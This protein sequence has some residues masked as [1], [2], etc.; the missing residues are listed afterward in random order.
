MI[1]AI[2]TALSDKKL[3]WPEDFNLVSSKDWVEK[4]KI[5]PIFYLH[6]AKNV[7]EMK[8]YENVLLE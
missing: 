5:D 6:H 7:E 4:M 8:E 2:L 1:K 3:D